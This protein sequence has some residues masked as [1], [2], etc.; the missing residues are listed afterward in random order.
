MYLKQIA[1]L[2]KKFDDFIFD[3]EFLKRRITLK[4]EKEVIKQYQKFFETNNNDFHVKHWFFVST[5]KQNFRDFSRRC[6]LNLEALLPIY[7][8]LPQKPSKI[9]NSYSS[10]SSLTLTSSEL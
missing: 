10:S 4:L 7:G 9:D 8:Y 5:I 3:K 6:Y 2:L 1:F